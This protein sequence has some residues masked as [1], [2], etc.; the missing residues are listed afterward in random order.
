MFTTLVAPPP[1]IARIAYDRSEYSG[2][3]ADCAQNVSDLYLGPPRGFH[4]VFYCFTV[5]GCV[6]ALAVECAYIS[7]K[8]AWSENRVYC[9]L[10]LFCLFCCGRLAFLGKVLYQGK[11]KQTG[12]WSKLSLLV[13]MHTTMITGLN[14]N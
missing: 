10:D 14:Y 7:R 13:E 3:L 5:S 1:R 9:C 12:V 4:F 2:L 8:A 6:L 11:Q